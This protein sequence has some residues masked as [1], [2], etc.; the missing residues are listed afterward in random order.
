MEQIVTTL[1]HECAKLLEDH[2]KEVGED[3]SHVLNQAVFLFNHLQDIPDNTHKFKRLCCVFYCLKYTLVRF[4][5][6]LEDPY[7]KREQNCIHNLIFQPQNLEGF[8]EDI[9]PYLKLTERFNSNGWTHL[10]TNSSTSN[11]NSLLETG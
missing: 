4:N 7:I 1:I 3:F 6:T 11:A 9:Q 2:Q 8:Y 5:N 10:E